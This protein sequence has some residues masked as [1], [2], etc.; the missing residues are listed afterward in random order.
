MS[1]GQFRRGRPE[2]R[3]RIPALAFLP[4][5]PL[6]QLGTGNPITGTRGETVTVTRST[7]RT[8]L[9]SSS[10]LT[11]VAVDSPALEPAG[12]S[13]QS[14]HTN[15]ALQSQTFGTA[16]WALQTGGPAT[17]GAPVLTV[18]AATAPDG[19]ATADQ[20]VYP[21]V[22]GANNLS[23]VVN[24]VNFTVV[25][26]TTYTIS[27]WVKGASGSGTTYLAVFDT[28]FTSIAINYTSTWQRFSFQRTASA[29]TMGIIIGTDRRDVTQANTLAQTVHIW[30]IQLEAAAYPRSYIPTTTLIGTRTMDAVV[31]SGHASIPVSSG[32]VELD[33][34]P[35]WSTHAGATI[36]DTRTA[37]SS[38]GLALY[39]VATTLTLDVK[40]SSTAAAVALTWVPGTTYRIKA[41]WG[42][43]G[44]LRLY[45]DGVLV[46][47]STANV[48]NN[49]PT[50][51][52]VIRLGNGFGGLSPLDGNIKNMKWFR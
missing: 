36:L 30:G 22:T 31:M 35:L 41:T 21:A 33:F 4:S 34:T 48:S 7:T 47:S 43:D 40:N 45:R 44:I 52:S 27:L 18:D 11:T 10:S 12:L 17:P 32:S 6:D 23:I 25:N 42:A 50:L 19:T 49:V 1:N 46:A 37:S 5:V 51:H 28:V 20:L 8:C 16:P 2:N 39:V 38:G 15:L 24:N 3:G 9:T 14:E 13:I 29:T 26:G